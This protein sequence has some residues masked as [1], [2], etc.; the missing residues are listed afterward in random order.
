[1]QLFHMP[2]GHRHVIVIGTSLGGLAALRAILAAFPEDLHAAVLVVMHVGTQRSLLPELLAP[3]CRLP[4]K[5]A[6]D[7]EPLARSVVYVAPP[8]RHLMVFEGP[9]RLSSGPKE[10]FARP[11]VD[12]LFRS[13]AVEFGER[14][15][16]IVLT[17]D[18][19]DGAAGIAA[20]KACGGW[21][22]VQDPSDCVAPSMPSSALRA[23]TADVIAPLDRLGDAIVDAVNQKPSEERRIVMD[24]TPIELETR[25]ALTGHSSPDDLDALGERSTLTCPDCG[26]VI[27]R[28]G[29]TEPLRYRCHT[30]HAFSNASLNAAQER[31][32]EEALWVSV[33]RLQERAAFALERAHVAQRRNERHEAAE[34]LERHARFAALEDSLRRFL[35]Q[36]AIERTEP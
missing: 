36:D 12:P 8:D 14:V 9:V 27:W 2:T 34:E 16:G 25:I 3:H 13:V 29:E 23:T 1:M 15:I 19:D 26:G 4:V 6:E 35:Q 21:V 5:H 11:A 32:V 10:N 20:I 17:G 7:D 18:L 22:A 33:R 31:S 30:G 28:V 24:K